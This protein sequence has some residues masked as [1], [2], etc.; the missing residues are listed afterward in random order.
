MRKLFREKESI[1]IQDQNEIVQSK[2][3][4]F[5]I[6]FGKSAFLHRTPNE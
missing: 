1:E 4:K 3:M 2:T 5:D 6:D